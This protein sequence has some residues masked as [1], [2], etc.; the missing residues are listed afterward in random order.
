MVM[1]RAIVRDVWQAEAGPALAMTVI[2]MLCAIVVSP[3]LGGLLV[4]IGGWQAPILMALLVAGAIVLA[5]LCF[6]RDRN[7]Q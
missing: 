5:G 2:G 3:A 6:Y 1:A 7:R 4:R